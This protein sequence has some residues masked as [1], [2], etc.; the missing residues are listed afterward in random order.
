MSPDISEPAMMSEEQAIE[1]L[2]Q[3][4]VWPTTWK[5]VDRLVGR[6]IEIEML[7][8]MFTN[9]RHVVFCKFRISCSYLKNILKEAEKR[10][11][12]AVLL[13]QRAL[14]KLRFRVVGRNGFGDTQE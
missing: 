1:H 7:E 14:K 11:K 9:S 2:A 4:G 13:F 12:E 5:R 8:Q 3:T 10:T 6:E